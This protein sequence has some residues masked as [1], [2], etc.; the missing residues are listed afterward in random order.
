[1]S[2]GLLDTSAYSAL[3]RGQ[4]VVRGIVAQLE[5]VCMCPIVL[6]ELR[7]GFL[8]GGRLRENEGLLARFLDQPGVE[9]LPIDEGTAERYAS[10]AAGLRRAGTPLPSN[11]IWIAA[12]A[13]QHGLRVLT[14][15]R[16]FLEIPQILVEVFEAG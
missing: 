14:L 8:L 12:S 7:L 2:G 15:D 11:D 9:I 1:M 4:P 6:G 16:H 10:I 5:R 3:G 13:M